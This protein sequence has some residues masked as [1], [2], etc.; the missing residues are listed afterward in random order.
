MLIN[1]KDLHTP[2][3]A[4]LGETVQLP[5]RVYD[6]LLNGIIKGDLAP[7][8]QLKADKIAQQLGVSSTPVRD[9]LSHLVEDGLVHKLPYQGWFVCRFQE[10]EI[11]DL[12]EMRANLEC[13]AVRQACKRITP[14]EVEQMRVLQA[15][16]EAALAREDTE[17]Y[18]QYNQRFH[19]GIMRAAKNSQLPVVFGQ[20]SLRVQMLS[21]RTIRRTGQPSRAVKEHHSLLDLIANHDAH[22]AQ[23]LMEG[24][25]LGALQEILSNGLC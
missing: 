1:K 18:R 5:N 8:T 3:F 9:A 21:A 2:E 6:A 11:R 12:Y 14:E 7:G 4:P 22:A 10:T 13:F 23:S 16:G 25:I 15:T 20:I 17:A 24:H 19:T